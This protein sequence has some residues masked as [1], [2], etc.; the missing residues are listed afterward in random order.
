MVT[1]SF[2]EFNG[3]NLEVCKFCY[4]DLFDIAALGSEYVCEQLVP[5]NCEEVS[6]HP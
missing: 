3:G 6:L 1:H 2:G 4:L 5:E